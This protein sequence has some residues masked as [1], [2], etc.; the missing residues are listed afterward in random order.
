MKKKDFFIVFIGIFVAVI[1]LLF[2]RFTQSGSGKAIITVNGRIYR[3]CPMS[4]DIEIDINGTNIA[5]I[6]N[7]EIYMKSSTCPDKIC[8][9]Q[10]KIHDSSKSIVCLPNG[11]VIRVEKSS[12]I[13]SVVR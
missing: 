7:G 11:V 13:D 1:C 8:I 3:E 4:T 2:Q 6:E 5:V 9:H 10:G 12:E